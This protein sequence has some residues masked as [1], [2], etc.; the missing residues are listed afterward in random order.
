M[1]GVAMI[2]N[3]CETMGEGHHET[4]QTACLSFTQMRVILVCGAVL[5]AVL[6]VQSGPDSVFLASDNLKIVPLSG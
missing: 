1:E 5:T 6:Q 4:C 2:I 3:L